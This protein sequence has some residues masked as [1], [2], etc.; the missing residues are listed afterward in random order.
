MIGVAGVPAKHVTVV[1]R[2]ESSYACNTDASPALAVAV[3]TFLEDEALFGIMASFPC[4]D[5]EEGFF[6]RKGTVGTFVM[7]LTT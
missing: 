3:L 5:R 7:V 2:R 6:L 1:P 4:L